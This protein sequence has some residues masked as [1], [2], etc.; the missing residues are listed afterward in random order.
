MYLQYT[1]KNVRMY[2][3]YCICTYIYIQSMS[4]SMFWLEGLDVVLWLEDINWIQTALAAVCF[5]L[6]KTS[7][8][9]G[10]Q[11]VHVCMYCTYCTDSI[12]R[13]SCRHIS[14]IQAFG[15]V[16]DYAVIRFCVYSWGS[17]ICLSP[18]EW[19]NRIKAKVRFP[20]GLRGFETWG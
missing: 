15:V 4:V 17:L 14:L 11:H 16:V 20:F 10:L 13:E 7:D 19:L 9:P 18:V 3:M 2:S 12:H 1:C 6:V 8:I 5:E